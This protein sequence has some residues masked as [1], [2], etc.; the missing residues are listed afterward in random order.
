MKL[1]RNPGERNLPEVFLAAAPAKAAPLSV[2]ILA[3]PVEL[4]RYRTA[5]EDLAASAVEANVFYEPWMLL[6]ALEA[7]GAGQGLLFALVL[8]GDAHAPPEETRLC[9]FFPLHRRRLHRRLPL[10]VLGLWQHIH[11]YLCTPLVRAG[12]VGATLTALFDWLAS[13]PRSAP[14]VEFN[15]MLAAGPVAAALRECCQERE[16][17]TVVTDSL[18]RALFQPG[19]DGECYLRSVLSGKRR[20]ALERRH[21]RLAE[22]AAVEYVALEPGGNVERWAEEFLQ[23]EASGWKG[24]SGTALAGDMRQRRFFH[25]ILQAAFERRR[26]LLCS[27]R[28]ANRP[29][30]FRCSFLAGDGAFAFKTTYDEQYSGFSPGLLLEMDHILRLH[31]MPGVQWMDSCTAA[32]NLMMNDLW[33]GRR[34]IHTVLAATG[35]GFGRPVVALY[36]WLRALKRRLTR[37]AD[38]PPP[39]SDTDTLEMPT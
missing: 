7:F 14:L 37:S 36:P 30:A 21:R 9:G 27:L 13:N 26:L 17:P 12:S 8:E 31:E 38:A 34:T 29:I 25:T 3:D 10:D 23:L 11:C 35:P 5:W 18:H 33:H 15:Q 28:L 22:T 32:D 6:P 19:D 20:R 4:A 1:C 39:S 16:N 2:R 24:Q